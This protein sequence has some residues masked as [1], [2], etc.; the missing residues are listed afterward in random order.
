MKSNLFMSR[1]RRL[2]KET[3]E[4]RQ[5]WVEDL[6]PK[7]ND[8]AA[9]IAGVIG[10]GG[11]LL[12]AGNGGSAA[13]ASHFAAEMVVRLTSKRNRQALP[14]IALGM[15]PAVVTAASNDYGYENM[16]ARQVEA[17]GH[18]GDLLL[19][20]ST[21]GNSANL[22]RAASVARE[23]GMLTAALLG[24]NGG[25]LA[26]LVE[27]CLIIPHHDTQRIQEEHSFVIH[28]LVETIES[29]LFG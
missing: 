1:L 11:K 6:G 7:L 20:I 12:I 10:S 3:S 8:L 28:L 16:F 2:A 13:D 25:R 23:K 29:D 17:L 14:A 21:S 24:G 27:R 18:K 15:D 19:A 22:L 5:S 9:V 26:E 4:L